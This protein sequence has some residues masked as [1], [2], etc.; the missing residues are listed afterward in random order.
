[1]NEEKIKVG[2]RTIEVA[3]LDKV[4][5]PD[6]GITQGDLMEYYRRV[7]ETMLPSCGC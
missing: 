2:S 3:N 5:F 7:A 1:M 4:M 6:E